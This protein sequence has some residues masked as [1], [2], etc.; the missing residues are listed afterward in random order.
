MSA[1]AHHWPIASSFAPR[2]ARSR[3]GAPTCAAGPSGSHM[4]SPMQPH[5]MHAFSIL[6]FPN[7]RGQGLE[8]PSCTQPRHLLSSPSHLDPQGILTVRPPAGEP[9]PC[10]ASWRS[11]SPCPLRSRS[12]CQQASQS[13]RCDVCLPELC[14]ANRRDHLCRAS[15]RGEVRAY[16]L[17]LRSSASPLLRGVHVFTSLP[18]LSSSCL[19]VVA[20][21][22]P[23]CVASC[24]S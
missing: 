24:L 12:S 5:L 1:R 21:S 9:P 17:L 6:P 20:P 23:S 11:A 15:F 22:R 4:A 8:A 2:T 13:R 16:L 3:A 18:A 14:R 19:V 7:H 10:P